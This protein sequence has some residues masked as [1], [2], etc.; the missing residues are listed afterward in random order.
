[1][2]VVRLLSV[3]NGG[4]DTQMFERCNRLE[5]GSSLDC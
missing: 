5:N 4:E 1:M 2:V 3:P